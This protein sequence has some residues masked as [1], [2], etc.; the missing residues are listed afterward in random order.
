MYKSYYKNASRI[1]D[2]IQSGEYTKMRKSMRDQA[3]QGL[4]SRRDNML[5]IDM[6]EEED[7][8][9][10]VASY[11]SAFRN[12]YRENAPSE[13]SVSDEEVLASLE[14]PEQSPRRDS[15]EGVWDY[16]NYDDFGERL[17]RSESSGRSDV[18][19]TATSS[20]REQ[21]MTGLWQFS[22]DRLKD[23]KNSTGASFTVEEFRNDEDLQRDVFAWHI[24]DIDNLID[25]NNLVEQ[26]YSRNGLRAVA[27]LGGRGG[28]LNWVRSGGTEN[29]SDR[30]GTTLTSYY[31]D[32][33]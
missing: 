12:D 29:P 24:Q 33:K 31:N 6:P 25:E 23:Y 11:I 18:Q 30:L 15:S 14:T 28:M 21:T 3:V 16:T 7:A 5:P 8:L 17:A 10:M 27:H 1:A 20:G 13:S 9:D 19:I 32:F 4:I 26:G 22:E 2:L